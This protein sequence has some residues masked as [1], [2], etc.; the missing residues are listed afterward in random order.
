MQNHRIEQTKKEGKNTI[1]SNTRTTIQKLRL[2]KS[3]D[4]EPNP[5]PIY[6]V[7]KNLPRPYKERQNK[8]FQANRISF[9]G[10]YKHLAKTFM[11]YLDKSHPKKRD[12]EYMPLRKN[13]DLLNNYS[14]QHHIFALIITMGPIPQICNQYLSKQTNPRGLDILRKLQKMPLDK[15]NIEQLD[16]LNTFFKNN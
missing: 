9:K 8:Y 2:K 10:T 5:G 16:T 3:G 6:N 14:Y 15:T 7:T 11:P 12:M 1:E 4:I 13:C